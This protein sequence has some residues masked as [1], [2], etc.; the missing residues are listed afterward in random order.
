[1]LIPPKQILTVCTANRCRSPMLAAVLRHRLA[2]HGLNSEF[3]VGSAGLFARG[4][5]PVEPTVLEL[6]ASRGLELAEQKSRPLTIQDIRQSHLILVAAEEHRLG[7]F[8]RSPENLYK[9]VLLS[10]LTGIHQDLD[11]P[12]DQPLAAFERTLAEIEQYVDTGWARLLALLSRAIASWDG[13]KRAKSLICG[14]STTGGSK[15][16]SKSQENCKNRQESPNI[17]RD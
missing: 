11:D 8:H 15:W 12:I 2:A 6:L 9:A 3:V 10:E 17:S 13:Q 5:E 1:M 7:I 16:S 4:G 14:K